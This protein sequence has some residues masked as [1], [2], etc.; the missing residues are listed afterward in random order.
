[1]ADI[2]TL[3]TRIVLRNDMLS[4]W[5][6][7]SKILL[8]GEAALAR[9][10]G[11]LS[12]YYQMRIGTGDKTWSQLEPSNIIIP[13]SNISGLTDA[14]LSTETNTT[15]QISA[16]SLSSG[17]TGS[18]FQLQSKEK[19]ASTWTNVAGSR[20]NVPE[21]NTAGLSAAISATYLSTST[22][23]SYKNEVGLSA[24]SS[25][26]PV[27]TKNDIAGIAGAM[28]FIGIATLSSP[29][30][31]P[32]SCVARTFSSAKNG[33]VAVIPSTSTE[34]LYLSSAPAKWIELGDETRYAKKSDIGVSGDLSADNTVYG[35]IAYEKGR[36]EAN[37]GYLS[38]AINAKISVDNVQVSGVN[39]VHCSQEDY[40]DKVI[41]GT[42]DANTVYFVSA[43]T[44]NLY[45]ESIINLATATS[46]DLS[47]A[48]NVEYVNSCVSA[49]AANAITSITLNGQ[50]FNVESQQATLSIECISCGGAST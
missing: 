29:T 9:L 33:D 41:N 23:N 3:N 8:K 6:A 32:I 39:L 49:L 24:A 18:S 12:S 42:I 22:F 20:F 46:S 44:F 5:N 31:D 15:Y 21:F 43:D 45:G 35:S 38:A 17:E 1:M 16:V 40:H 48:A 36:R 30:E 4:N 13:F 34:Y 7:S 47:N 11:D 10:S 19:G 26:N 37:D 25:G 27:A 14:I 50:L 2:K 28:H